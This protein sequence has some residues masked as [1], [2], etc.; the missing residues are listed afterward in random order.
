M[1]GPAPFGLL[2][3]P[4]EAVTDP[5][6]YFASR[7]HREALARLT[8]LVDE[9][10]M[11][12]GMLTGDI[13][14][15]KSLTRRVFTAQIDQAR[16]FVVAFEN[17]AFDTRELLRQLFAR[18]GCFPEVNL[19]AGTGRLFEYV[20]ALVE[21]LHRSQQRQL[22]LVI[23]EA[24]DLPRETLLD[25]KRLS[26]LN[27]EIAGSLTTILIGQPELRGVVESLPPLNQRISLRFH[28]LN[29]GESEVADYLAHRLRVAGHFSGEVFSADCCRLLFQ[30]SRGVPREINRVAKL[31]L[32]AAAARGAASV[33]RDDVL[34][35]LEDLRQQAHIPLVSDLR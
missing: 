2:E 34:A 13:G 19:D 22:V 35:V 29:L 23:D 14:S 11:Y 17:S 10:T 18:S 1:H 25:L 30:A 20:A 26:N 8:Y 3:R 7:E 24:Q 6:F 21:E 9:Q 28:L 27:G 16:H 12:F 5:R 33:A 32:D 15:G 31:S 4:F